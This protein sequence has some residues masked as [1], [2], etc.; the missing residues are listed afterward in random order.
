MKTKYLVLYLLIITQCIFSLSSKAETFNARA[1]ESWLN[2]TQQHHNLAGLTAVVVKE[3]KIVFNRSFGVTNI[4]TKTDMTTEHLFDMSSMGKTAITVAVLQLVEQGK[5]ELEAPVI[6]YLPYFKMDDKR[7]VNITIKQLLT[8]TSGI[9]NPKDYQ[10]QNP[11]TDDLALERWVKQQS[12]RKLNFAPGKK[13]GYSDIA[14]EIVGD[15]IAKASGVSF[16]AY[17]KANVFS[18]LGMINSTFLL[19]DIPKNLRVTPHSQKQNDT[20][21]LKFYPYNRRHAPSSAYHTNGDDMAKWLAAFSSEKRLLKTGLLKAGSIKNM[22]SVHYSDNDEDKMLL[23]WFK[24]INKER[25]LYGH[26]GSD[27]GF[28]SAMNV[29]A[30]RDAGY[31]LMINTKYKKM[32]MAAIEEALQRAIENKVLPKVPEIINN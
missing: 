16:E 13:W 2:T 10:Y 29:Y 3:G 24:S 8:H 9:P 17:M 27:K 22:W 1:L 7:A 26:G 19:A 18:P 15:V 11:Q 4:N 32:P 6:K 31:G 20:Y 25:V 28:I 23:G 30:D 5:I 12:D 14:F 21:A